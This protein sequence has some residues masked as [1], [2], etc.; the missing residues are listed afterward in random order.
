MEIRLGDVVRLKKQ[1]PCGSYEWTVVRVG[2]DIRVQCTQCQRMV[3]LDRATFERRVTG[4]ISRGKSAMDRQE[5]EAKQLSLQAQLA[6]LQRR[7]PAHSV[8]LAMWQELE[9]LE[10]ELKAVEQQLQNG[11]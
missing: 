1:H 9:K 11:R 8:P 10:D 3:M 7:W 2:A 6:D 5:L 4:T